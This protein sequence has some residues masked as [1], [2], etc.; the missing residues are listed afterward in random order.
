MSATF[1]AQLICD[2]IILTVV[3]G[4]NNETYHAGSC[5]A[6]FSNTISL[7]SFLNVRDKIVRSLEH[8]AKLYFCVF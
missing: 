2:L 8:W 5:T 4:T 1:P 7:Y 6:Y 3:K